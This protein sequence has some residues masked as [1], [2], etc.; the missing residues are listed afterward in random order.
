MRT[1]IIKNMKVNLTVVRKF[2]D[3]YEE[4]KQCSNGSDKV[5]KRGRQ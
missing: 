5:D 4:M 2:G 1:M 3:D